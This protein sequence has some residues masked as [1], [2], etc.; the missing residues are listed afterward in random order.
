MTQQTTTVA[1]DVQ[2][3]DS[4]IN[5]EQTTYVDI[6]LDVEGDVGYDPRE[7]YS[8]DLFS[9]TKLSSIK[10][11]EIDVDADDLPTINATKKPAQRREE[12]KEEEQTQEKETKQERRTSKTKAKVRPEDV[13]IE[14]ETPKQE[15]ADKQPPFER[16]PRAVKEGIDPDIEYLTHLIYEKAGWEKDDTFIETMKSFTNTESIIDYFI[17]LAKQNAEEAQRDAFAN[18]QIYQINRLMQREGMSLEEAVQF[19]LGNQLTI[20]NLSDVE[21]VAMKMKMDGFSE[22]EIQDELELYQGREDKLSRKAQLARKFFKELEERRVNE[23]L[24]KIQQRNEELRREV[25]TD[26]KSIKHFGEK[27]NIVVSEDQKKGMIDYLTKPVGENGETQFAIDM[28]ND[29]E[30]VY[31]VALLKQFDFDIEKLVDFYAKVSRSSIE[32]NIFSK[33]NNLSGRGD[34][35]DYSMKEEYTDIADTMDWI[36]KYKT[37]NIF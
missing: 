23:E 16:D 12:R 8:Y 35:S 7:Q 36:K 17:D 37:P 33:L 18:D 13:E 2:L 24:Q 6:N 27:G 29:K 34:K 15:K 3:G 4:S 32:R 11:R 22:D 14:K 21:V 1:P 20:D 31:A 30:A 5:P 9:Q 26:I 19:V 10:E 25:I 28:N